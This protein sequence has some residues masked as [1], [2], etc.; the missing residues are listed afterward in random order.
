MTLGWRIQGC[1]APAIFGSQQ[2]Q[3]LGLGHWHRTR[4]GRLAYKN[5]GAFAHKSLIDGVYFL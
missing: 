5:H 1:I 3:T 2:F 4:G